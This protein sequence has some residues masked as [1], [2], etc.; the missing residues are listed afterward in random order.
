[1]T[2]CLK[3]LAVSFGLTASVAAAP[4]MAEVRLTLGNCLDTHVVDG[5]ERNLGPG[6]ELVLANGV[7]QLVVDCTVSVGRSEDETFPETSE[8]LV[9]RFDAS[10][11]ALTLAAPTIRSRQQ[12][13][14]FNRSRDLRLQTAGGDEVGYQVAVLEK[15]GFQVF[16]DYLRE[17]EVF[18]RSSSPAATS[19]FRAPAVA[20]AATDVKASAGQPS[21]A[22]APD[23]ELV[24]QMLRYWYLKADPKTRNEWKNWI[25][26]S[27]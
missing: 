23:Q 2:H 9:V 7:H 26:S 19:G 18:N 22:A 20:G 15:E 3:T 24:N 10:D 13:E 5:K 27:E 4:V 25:L 1:M 8:A 21:G 14:A 11:S 16:R 6:A 12:L 17:V